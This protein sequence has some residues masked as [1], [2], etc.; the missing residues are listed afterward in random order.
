[1]RERTRYR[2]GPLFAGCPAL[3]ALYHQR[4]GQQSVLRG[5]ALPR[6]PIALSL[7]RAPC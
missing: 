2:H 1:M 3:T 4:Q 6:L 5:A 7:R